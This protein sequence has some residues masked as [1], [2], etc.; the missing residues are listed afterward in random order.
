MLSSEESL[1]CIA[2]VW[3]VLSACCACITRGEGNSA[4]STVVNELVRLK[5]A[6]VV[7]A[8][9][10]NLLGILA[11]ISLEQSGCL[12]VAGIVSPQG[13]LDCLTLER[14]FWS[15]VESEIRSSQF[16][17]HPHADIF[18]SML[19]CA[20]SSSNSCTVACQASALLT[21]L[22]LNKT[23]ASAYCSYAPLLLALDMARKSINDA[24]THCSVVLY[25]PVAHPTRLFQR[26]RS[27]STRVIR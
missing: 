19:I 15:S 24:G 9:A 27:C 10:A 2:R 13:V 5:G 6:A 11:N 23:A 26:G 25:L 17:T 14:S 16:S 4:T 22:C 18:L 12:I 20:G 7:V 3:D 1:P 21:N 8:C